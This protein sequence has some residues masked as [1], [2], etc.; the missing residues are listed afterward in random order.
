MSRRPGALRR[1]VHTDGGRPEQLRRVWGDVPAWCVDAVPVGPPPA[2]CANGGP[3]IILDGGPEL[4]CIG[5]AA[6]SFSYGLCT[7]NDVGVNIISSAFLIDAFDSAVDPYQPGGLGGSLGANGGVHTSSAFEVFGDLRT[8]AGQGLNVGGTTSVHQALHVGEALGLQSSLDV[9]LDAYVGGPITGNAASTIGGT[10]YTPSCASVPGSLSATACVDQA[11]TVPQPCDCSPASLLPLDAIVSYYADP[12]HNWN[13]LIQLDQ[14]AL[15]GPGN[16]Q[17]LVLPCGIYYLTEIDPGN[18]I[19]IYVEGHTAII[20]GGSI[21]IGSSVTFMLSTT[22]TL[23]VIVG[24]T[25]HAT[26]QFDVGSPAYPSKSRFYVAGTCG[27][28]GAACSTAADCC[29]LQCNGTQCEGNGDG[30]PA[31][32][33]FLTSNTNLNGGF[34]APFGRF[35]STSNLEMF[36]ALFLGWYDAESETSIHYDKNF[37]KEGADCPGIDCGDCSDCGGQACIN[38]SCGECTS[39]GQ[40]CPPLYCVNGECV[41]APEPQ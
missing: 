35:I 22:S 28:D 6:D 27:G 40:C 4:L 41:H 1:R 20:V 14:E 7:C 16:P 29:S 3:P 30:G 19:T 32:S 9:T 17:A 36:G 21:E 25:V 11:V 8:S 13:S 26:A 12:A 23:D 10:L 5:D 31:F 34:Y 15:A 37:I 24:G 38:G 18:P 33:V 39:D 2:E